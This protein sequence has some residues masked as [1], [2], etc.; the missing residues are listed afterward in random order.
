M[1]SAGPGHRRL[2][3]HAADP[4]RRAPL[5]D[6]RRRQPRRP[7][8]QG[9]VR[10]L[11]HGLLHRRLGRRGPGLHGHLVPGPGP[12]ARDAPL[13]GRRPPAH[14]HGRHQPVH[15][16]GLVDLDRPE[17]HACPSA[18]RAGCSSTARR[19]RRSW[20]RSSRPSRSPEVADDPGHGH[21]RRLRPVPHL[22]GR[23]RPGPGPGRPVPAAVQAGHQAD[24]RPTRG[25]SAA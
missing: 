25:P 17:R 21:P 6:V 5:R 3:D 2:P 23:R 18:T 1:L 24:R 22:R 19:T 12:D 10:A 14:R 20:T 15:G 13:G 11:G 9:R 8:H 16:A 7:V 4:G